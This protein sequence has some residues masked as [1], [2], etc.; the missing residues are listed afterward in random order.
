VPGN[1]GPG[2]TP[3]T[4]KNQGRL[5]RLILSAALA[6]GV[7]LAA[8]GGQSAKP[9]KE[10]LGGDPTRGQQLI[11]KYGCGSCHM[12]HGIKGATGNVG[13]PLNG[14]ATREVIGGRLPNT[15]DNMI[16]WI[17]DPQGVSPGTQMP[18]LGVSADEAR[19]I[20]AYLHTLK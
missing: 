4:I 9:L 5:K 12:I 7:A 13:P 6:G 20:T 18:N 10:V 17:T 19:D 15:P 1:H 2:V 8:C 11:E 14:I 16:R 3:V